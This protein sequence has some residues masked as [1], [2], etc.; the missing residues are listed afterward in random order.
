MVA[1][2]RIVEERRLERGKIEASGE[3]FRLVRRQLDQAGRQSCAS[4][5]A[6]T[7]WPAALIGPSWAKAGGTMTSA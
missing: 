5:S 6:N 1:R 3:G 7:V 2:K 4:V